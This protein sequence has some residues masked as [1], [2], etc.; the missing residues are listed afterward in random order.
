MLIV[1]LWLT[2]ICESL[3]T[4]IRISVRTLSSLSVGCVDNNANSKIIFGDRPAVKLHIIDAIRSVGTSIRADSGGRRVQVWQLWPDSDHQS[5]PITMLWL[6]MSVANNSCAQSKNAIQICKVER[7][8]L[9]TTNWYSICLMC[10]MWSITAMPTLPSVRHWPD[11][12][13]IACAT[14][15]TLIAIV[16]SLQ[17]SH[18]F[19]MVIVCYECH[20]SHTSSAQRYSQPKHR[21]FWWA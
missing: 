8:M 1:G 21:I 10:L 5:M 16:P 7:P 2:K 20:T 13:H 4:F 14:K 3:Q 17:S 19:W 11:R 18:A 6:W 9:T 15:G 12:P